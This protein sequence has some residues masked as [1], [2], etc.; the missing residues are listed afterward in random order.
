MQ[1]VYSKTN[2]QNLIIWSFFKSQQCCGEKDSILRIG[3]PFWKG[4]GRTMVWRL[5]LAVRSFWGFGRYVVQ[6]KYPQPPERRSLEPVQFTD[7]K[8]TFFSET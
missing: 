3:I 7:C 6:K 2:L 1:L 4:T 8:K 5:P